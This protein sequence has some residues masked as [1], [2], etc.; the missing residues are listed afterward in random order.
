MRFAKLS[1]AGLCLFRL[2]LQ[3]A[4]SAAFYLFVVNNACP[5]QCNTALSLHQKMD[6][7]RAGDVACSNPLDGRL[8]L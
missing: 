3:H 4:S 6:G 5:V 7:S 2:R 1:L 8:V